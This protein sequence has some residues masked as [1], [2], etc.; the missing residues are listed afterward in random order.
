MIMVIN[1]GGGE[2]VGIIDAV[3]GYIEV[4]TVEEGAG[5]FFMVVVDLGGGATALMGGVAE[6]ATGAGIHGGKK[7]EIGRIGDFMVSS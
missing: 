5:E 7:H 1:R 6:V 2:E 4:D 3:G